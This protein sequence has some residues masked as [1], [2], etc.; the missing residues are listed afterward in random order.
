MKQPFLIFA[1]LSTQLLFAQRTDLSTLYRTN[2][3]ILNPAATNHFYLLDKH[4][5][6]AI[7]ITGRGQKSIRYGGGI[8]YN[9]AGAFSD[10]Y[11][12]GNFTYYLV[13]NRGR[14]LSA[15]INLG[16]RNFRFNLFHESININP[17]HVD[18]LFS[19]LGEE[20]NLQQSRLNVGAGLFYRNTDIGYR[21]GSYY[22]KRIPDWYIGLSIAPQL[23]DFALNN[24]NY[25]FNRNM[26][27]HSTN[28]AL[29]FLSNLLYGFD[30]L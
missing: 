27:L 22:K 12:Y 3:S 13:R 18:A 25:D 8:D 29:I 28:M 10:I 11:A 26:E 23:S 1:L 16:W 30:M 4:H 7:T 14:E 20:N 5:N 6:T 21:I 24:S 2:W 19:Y 9:K 17:A 15:G